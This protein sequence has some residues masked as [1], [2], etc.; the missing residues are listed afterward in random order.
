MRII[1]NILYFLR[2]TKFKIMFKITFY[3]ELV[4]TIVASFMQVEVPLEREAAYQLI[5][6]YVSFLMSYLHWK[7]DITLCVLSLI[8]FF[9]NRAIIH[10][11]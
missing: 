4:I 6:S 7:L 1:A 11:E 2:P 9:A 10:D 5:A 8:P 3:L